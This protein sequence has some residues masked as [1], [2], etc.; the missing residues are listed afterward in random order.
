MLVTDT[1]REIRRRISDGDYDPGAK[2]NEVALAAEYD[3]SRNTLRE[4]FV[5]LMNQGFVHKIPN[6]GVFIAEP[7]ID[8]V[9]D[10][11][12]ARLVIEPA[13]LAHGEFLDARELR[14]QVLSAKKARGDGDLPAVAV[15]NQRFHRA[16]VAGLGSRELDELMSRLLATMRL[17]FLEVLRVEPDFHAD[18]IAQNEAIAE[19]IGAG[20]RA[21]AAEKMRQQLQAT[22][23]RV[24][25]ILA[26]D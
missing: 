18:Y 12:R 11:Y 19:L 7:G 22:S 21:E 26:G 1:A 4:A 15:A 25:E 23:A 3:V 5:M 17:V 16:V 14:A 9:I 20:Q 24:C 8:D 2:L 10:T 13:G 6:R